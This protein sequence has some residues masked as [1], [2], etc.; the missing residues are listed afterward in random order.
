MSATE[1]A[2]WSETAPTTIDPFAFLLCAS[3]AC[4]MVSLCAARNKGVLRPTN[5]FQEVNELA[6]SNLPPELTRLGHP[7]EYCF[8]LLGPFWADKRDPS[9]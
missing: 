9:N 2:G 5:L 6:L 3:S 1:N 7:Q 8:D 4:A